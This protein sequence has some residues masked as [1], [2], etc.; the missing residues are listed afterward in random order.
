MSATTHDATRYDATEAADA[1]GSERGERERERC[2]NAR[3]L[4]CSPSVMLLVGSPPH[5]TTSPSIWMR[6]LHGTLKPVKSS[7]R[8]SGSRSP[9][10]ACQLSRSSP[11]RASHVALAVWLWFDP[12]LA[13]P[14][15]LGLLVFHRCSGRNSRLCCG[16]QVVHARCRAGQQWRSEQLGNLLRE[17]QGC[18]AV[19][20][21]RHAGL[22]LRGQAGPPLGPLLPRIP[23]PQTAQIRTRS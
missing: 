6:L 15:Q 3:D 5:R 4:G 9:R 21:R 16:D 17:R 2:A 22:R 19:R 12:L 7:T 20:G 18:C 13:G 11:R 10:A 14:K 1:A 8:R 23:L